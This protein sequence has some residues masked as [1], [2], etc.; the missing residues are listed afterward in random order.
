MQFPERSKT[1][2]N[3]EQGSE[4]IT[5]EEYLQKIMENTRK[6]EAPPMYISRPRIRRK[7]DEGSYPNW[8]VP[9]ENKLPKILR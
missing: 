1:D 5:I 6:K 9:D 7:I 8:T 3:L 4:K 2:K